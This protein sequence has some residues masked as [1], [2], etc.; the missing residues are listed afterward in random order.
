MGIIGPSGGGKTT[1]ADL[2]LRLI[3]PTRGEIYI[4]GKHIKE[5]E[6]GSWRRRIMY[7]PQEPFLLN[8]TIKENILFFGD[9][10]QESIEAAAE[11]AQI[12]DFISSLPKGYDT[13]VGERGTRLSGGERQR[14]ALA[15]S[16]AR[17]PDILVLDEATS[18]VDAE[19]ERAIHTTLQR[20]H[21]SKT[22]IIIAHRLRTVSDADNLLIIEDGVITEQGSPQ[23]LA[24]RADSYYSRMLSLGEHAPPVS[25]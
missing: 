10:S 23:E 4:D 11:Q 25:L 21:G 22:I 14:I 9:F 6:L 18:A 15:R 17:D 20:L 2:L 24:R 3:E 8:G 16:L 19:S 12:H 5:I 1:L 7:V 13:P